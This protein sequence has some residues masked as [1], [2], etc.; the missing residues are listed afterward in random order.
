MTFFS[1]YTSRTAALPF[2][3]SPPHIVRY[4]IPSAF[5]FKVAVFISGFFTAAF[6][7]RFLFA[8]HFTSTGIPTPMSTTVKCDTPFAAK[9]CK[10]YIIDE[11]RCYPPSPCCLGSSKIARRVYRKGVV[12]AFGSGCIERPRTVCAFGQFSPRPASLLSS[13]DAWAA[14]FRPS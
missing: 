1:S 12:I 13:R 2:C 11:R 14:P 5:H 6:G 3:P 8:F 4:I 7:E 10:G 9:V